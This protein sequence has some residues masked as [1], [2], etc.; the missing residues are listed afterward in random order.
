MDQHQLYQQYQPAIYQYIFFLVQNKELAED[1]TQ[2]T[3]Y[4][5]FKN[6]ETFR[7]DAE[8]NT[9]LH[10][11]ARNLAY[12]YFRRKKLIQFIPFAKV[13][14]GMTEDLPA[15]WV[16]HNEQMK[17]LFNAMAKLKF[18]YREVLI[19]RKIKGLSVKETSELLGYSET[20]VKNNTARAIEA[21]RKNWKG[22]DLHE[23]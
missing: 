8:I 20:K 10:R 9:W 3:F 13:Y 21:L 19:L 22:G 11:I 14:E 15:Q 7:Q 18:A 4:K 12:D 1:L 2:E 6:I 17:E 5:C 16:E 23:K